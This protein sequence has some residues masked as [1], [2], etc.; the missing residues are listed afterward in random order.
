MDQAVHVDLQS[1]RNNKLILS[2]FERKTNKNCFTKNNNFPSQ[3][4]IKICEIIN[5]VFYFD[6]N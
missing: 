3:I 4:A 6:T 1:Y 2:D 5:C